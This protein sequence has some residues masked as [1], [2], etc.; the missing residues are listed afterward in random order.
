[1]IEIEKLIEEIYSDGISLELRSDTPRDVLLASSEG[2][3]GTEVDNGNFFNWAKPCV[4]FY[5]KSVEKHITL[6]VGA[7][8]NKQELTVRIGSS[9]SQKFIL[10]DGENKID[11]VMPENS[12]DNV[13][14]SLETNSFFIPV[15]EKLNVDH[16]KLAFRF[17]NLAPTEGF[18]N[19]Q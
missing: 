17:V 18:V 9:Q 6:T 13:V 19:V 5:I 11:L 10:H 3:Y 16:R 8:D 15:R 12:E 4:K 2:L 1:M 14:M 7:I